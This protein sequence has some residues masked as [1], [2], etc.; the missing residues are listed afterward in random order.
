MKSLPDTLLTDEFIKKEL[1]I[2]YDINLF[3]FN[4]IIQSFLYRDKASRCDSTN[5]KMLISDLYYNLHFDKEI[6]KYVKK[7]F[8]EEF[9][10]DKNK[11]TKEEINILKNEIVEKSLNTNTINDFTDT[12]IKGIKRN[13][14]EINILNSDSIGFNDLI[15]SLLEEEEENKANIPLRKEKLF[16][17]LTGRKENAE[18]IWNQG[19]CLRDIDKIERAKKI[20][21]KD[22]LEKYEKMKAEFGIY[23]YRG[24][25]KVCNRHGHSNDLP[26]YWAYGYQ[27]ISEMKEN[28][29]ESFIKDYYSKHI[30]CCGLVKK[31]LSYRQMRKKAKREGLIGG[32]NYNNKKSSK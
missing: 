23:L 19:N 3:R 29:K 10:K 20:F 9:Q 7:V 4:C 22:W 18:I 25:D 30:R 13:S 2:D 16:I 21:D 6:K 28:E 12:L 26:S 15:N 14:I 8:Q 11:K 17:L 24:G 1:G 32:V 5:K 31:E 27:S